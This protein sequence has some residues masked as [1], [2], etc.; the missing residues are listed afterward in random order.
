MLFVVAIT[1]ADDEG[2]LRAL[3]T[4][5]VGHGY[6]YDADALANIEA[7]LRELADAGLGVAS[8]RSSARA[9]AS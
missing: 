5:I 4:L 1:M 3:P 2:R 6:A 9:T 8:P 7:W